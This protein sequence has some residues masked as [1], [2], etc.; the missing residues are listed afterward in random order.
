ME[1]KFRFCKAVFGWCV[2]VHESVY[3]QAWVCVWG[4]TGMCV[5]ACKKS[6]IERE[7]VREIRNETAPNPS[8][9][10][11]QTLKTGLV[12]NKER[13]FL[14]QTQL[15]PCHTK[16]EKSS[17]AFFSHSNQFRTYFF[18]SK[19]FLFCCHH[20]FFC[21]KVNLP[22]KEISSKKWINFFIETE[23]RLNRCLALKLLWVSVRVELFFLEIAKNGSRW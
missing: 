11:H 20:D 9:R 4:Y 15:H 13:S 22:W 2:C 17:S 1:T 19:T 23:F 14:F 3:E 21:A 16:N 8:S 7:R 5:R 18:L 12:S 6:E 10:W